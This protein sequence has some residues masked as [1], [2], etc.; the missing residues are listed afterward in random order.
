MAKAAT[1]CGEVIRVSALD[2]SR[3]MNPDLLLSMGQFCTSRR[4]SMHRRTVFSLHS[5]RAAISSAVQVQ[6]SRSID[7]T[8]WMKWGFGMGW[9]YFGVF[10]RVWQSPW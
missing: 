6:P 2:G 9:L 1:S 8:A 10:E 5:M 4:C 7:F 3:R